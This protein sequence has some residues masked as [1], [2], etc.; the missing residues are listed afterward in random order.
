M[1]KMYRV[2]G[3][4]CAACSARVEKA[5]C[6]VPGVEHVS[7]NLLTGSMKADVADGQEQAL[8]AAVEKAGYGAFPEEETVSAP[9]P[10]KE[11]T[12]LRRLIV[13]AVLFLPLFYIA[14]GGMLGL[15]VPHAVAHG[16]TNG[17]LQLLLAIPILCINRH[18]FTDGFRAIF[19][20]S[21]NMNSLVSIGSAAGLV[22]SIA[23]LLQ[24]AH[25][26]DGGGTLGMETLYFESSTMILVLVSVG[27]YLEA[28]AKGKTG[29]AISRLVNLAPDTAVLLEDGVE[30]TVPLEKLKIDDV[31]VV[32]EGASV[33][34]DGVVLTGRGAVDLSMLTGESLP[35]DVKP[36]DEVAA[37]TVSR[38]GYFTFRVTKL[39]KDTQLSKIVRLVEEATAS[40]APVSR[41]ADRVS[42]VFVPIVMG[43]ALITFAGWRIAGAEVAEALKHA[44][45]VLVI[46]CPCA[47]GLAT[48][49]AIMVG[50]GKGAEM[51]IMI[52]SAADLE[53]AHKI[54][55]VAF[56]KTGTLTEGALRLTGVYASGIPQEDL[57]RLA[58]AVEKK[59][60]HPL[61]RAITA[62]APDSPEAEDY[63][64]YL[65]QGVSGTVE[66]KTIT[67][68]SPDYVGTLSPVPEKA[69]NWISDSLSRGAGVLCLCRDGE[70]L[71]AFAVEDRPRVN[72]KPALE[73]LK[74]LNVR[75]IMLTGDAEETARSIAATVGVD[76]VKSRLL[77]GDKQAVVKQLAQDVPVMMV[78]DGINDAPALAEATLGA[79]MGGGTDV[80]IESA[81]IVFMRSDPLLAADAIRLGRAVMRNIKQNL[82][83]AFLYNL[84]GV[85]VAAGALTG[86]GISPDPMFAAAAMSLS[87]F[88]VVTNALRLR[89]F[90]PTPA[91]AP[92]ATEEEQVPIAIIEEEK[93][94]KKTVVIEGMMCPHCVK[95]V[96]NALAP[97]DPEVEV[98]LGKKCAVIAA[99]VAD[100][101]I[102]KAVADAG[103]E[104]VRI[105]A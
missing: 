79:A 81:G 47:L 15:P 78:G 91:P 10:E 64:T 88:C 102:R 65:G 34:A 59:S 16:M 50:M 33:P 92:Q 56:D 17:L 101:D 72:A 25:T 11:D 38:E 22:Y 90:R 104:V 62:A 96:T 55:A 20:L 13:S 28:R 36:G 86:I 4:S 105:E 27:K 100:E 45:A 71:G 30:R 23:K 1:S 75:S 19:R 37:G 77:P 6:A 48:P 49:T 12:G 9:A 26:L 82:M 51:G 69:K 68:G 85:P 97:F 94:M 42:A 44:I 40:K 52:K 14:M 93:T 84:I 74:A 61:D 8:I 70:F 87:S 83:W 18:F 103:Y 99:S 98:N 53:T 5:A 39:G 7:V 58:A 57:L 32:K 29:D 67:V 76:E 60:S 80:A 89:R 35:V 21:P 2:T 3:M 54:A 73:A 43:L 66:G 46:S 63:R 41:L 24:M 31:C 95:H